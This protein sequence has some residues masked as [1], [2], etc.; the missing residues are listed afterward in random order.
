MARHFEILLT[1]I[2]A[3]PDRAIG[4]LAMLGDNEQRRMLVEWNDTAAAYPSQSCIHELFEA[5]V[6][7]TPDA[8]AVEFP[9]QH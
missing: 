6:A 3:N 4:S 5:Q 2:A 8:I 9:P 7:R 1:D